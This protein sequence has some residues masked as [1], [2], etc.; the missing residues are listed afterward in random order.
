[1]AYFDLTVE[2]NIVFNSI[3]EEFKRLEKHINSC[4]NGNTLLVF[5]TN[6]LRKAWN[7]AK[8]WQISQ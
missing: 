5:D 2:E 7:V 8:Y 4:Y 1:M 6:K 3:D